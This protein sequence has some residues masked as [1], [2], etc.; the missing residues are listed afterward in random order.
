VTE[1]QSKK[2]TRPIVRPRFIALATV[3]GLFLLFDFWLAVLAKVERNSNGGFVLGMC[4]AQVVLLATWTALGPAKLLTRTISGFCGTMLIALAL[5]AMISRIESNGEGW[6]FF[7]VILSQW[8]V[9]QIPLWFFRLVFTFRLCW[10]GEQVV[11]S[12][13]QDMQFGIGQ[14]MVWTA[15][16]GITLGIGQLLIPDEIGRSGLRVESIALVTLLT[17][18]NCLLAW[19][20]IWSTLAPRRWAIWLVAASFCYV[21]LSTAEN[22]SFE[23]AI[24]NPSYRDG[25]IFWII[26]AVQ[27]IAATVALLA[28]RINGFR[29][30]RIS[31]KAS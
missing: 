21:G 14:L 18:Y 25:A 13:G 3:L 8:I 6:L 10:P 23:A 29:L 16:V 15:L 28:M 27:S 19:P 22:I 17:V 31:P 2:P 26:N 24:G 5:V 4:F 12:T 20:F 7:V 30:I 1:P 9:I 11:T